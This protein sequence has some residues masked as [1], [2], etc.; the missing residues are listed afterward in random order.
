MGSTVASVSSVGDSLG[1]F[2]GF[3]SGVAGSL[4]SS[5]GF[6]SSVGFASLVGTASFVGSALVSHGSVS[7]CLRVSQLALP[8]SVLTITLIHLESLGISR[9]QN[10]SP[11]PLSPGGAVVV[12]VISPSF[13]KP[14]APWA[15]TSATQSTSTASEAKFV[16]VALHSRQFLLSQSSDMM[17]TLVTCTSQAVAGLVAVGSTGVALGGS[18]RVGVALGGTGVA[19][20]TTGVSV[21]SGVFSLSGFTVCVGGLPGVLLG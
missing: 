18:G 4:G 1:G 19:V 7:A 8:V 15:S 12:P 13:V 20:G 10:V 14:P 16:S 17:V 2:V 21:G 6:R 9:S 5:V 11:I 3:D